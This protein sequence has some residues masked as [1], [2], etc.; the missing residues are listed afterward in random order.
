VIGQIG[1]NDI[2]RIGGH[3]RHL[4]Q[5]AFKVIRRGATRPALKERGSGFD[6][7]D[8]LRDRRGD[9]LVEGYAILLGKPGRG[10]LDRDRQ[11]SG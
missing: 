3:I 2:I 10:G 9:P 7:T 6:D 4:L 1:R 8:F 11:L 5:D